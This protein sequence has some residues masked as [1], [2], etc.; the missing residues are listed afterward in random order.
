MPF[1]FALSYTEVYF[2]LSDVDKDYYDDP[3]CFLF[4]VPPN[5]R[6]ISPPTTVY[7]IVFY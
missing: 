1:F 7:I 3:D 2:R 5:R 4:S 6:T